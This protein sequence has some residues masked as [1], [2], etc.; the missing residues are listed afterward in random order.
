M[1]DMDSIGQILCFIVTDT[2]CCACAKVVSKV[3]KHG[4]FEARLHRQIMT[5]KSGIALLPCE[6]ATRFW[7]AAV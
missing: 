3:E 4:N 7:L 5:I 1:R 6:A 2:K